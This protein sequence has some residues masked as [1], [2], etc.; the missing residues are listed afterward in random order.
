MALSTLTSFSFPQ[1]LTFP[2]PFE[3]AV[4]SDFIHQTQ[5]RVK[6]WHSPTSLSLNWTN[7]GP[8]PDKIEGI[9]KYWGNE[10]DWS[11][12]ESQ[13]N[14]NWSHYAT[15]VSTTG[16]YKAPVPL[17]FIHQRSTEA[18]AVPLLL[19][20]GW[21]STHMEWSKVI[22]PLT[23]DSSLSFHVV[24]PDLPGFG[25]SPAP[26]EPG[27]GPR[28]T[29]QVMDGLMKQ[30]GYS[31]YGIVSTDLG[32]Q[33][34]MWMTGDAQASIIGHFTDFFPV[35]STDDDLT[36]LA[37]NRTSPEET[38]Y[39][40]ALDGWFSSHSA[41]S[42][43]HGQKPL[44]LSLALTDSPVGFLG[45]VWDLI[46]A[47]SDGHEYTY[48]ELITNALMLLIPGPY[49]NIRTYLEYNKA[50]ARTFP[51]SDVPTGVSEWGSANGPFPELAH[52]PLTPRSWIERTSNVQYFVQHAYGGHFPAVSHPKEWVQ[53]V[54]N[55]FLRLP[56]SSNQQLKSRRHGPR[57]FRR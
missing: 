47:I 13:L 40:R 33:V 38:V 28:Q 1:G 32:W 25:F 35:E 23:Q 14:R 22:E 42:A 15:S 55:F 30:L 36:R 37:Q 44:A 17:H 10:Y 8:P 54:R 12:F 57:P 48:D 6:T 51:K 34:A 49:S 45:W 16:K 18:D 9:A 53:N 21:P 39:M 29:G 11:A 41:Y 4:N 5:A 50:G 26:K 31:K 20:H 27:L 24:A 7:E 3:I 19:L 52:F 56:R 2:Q 46:Y 43:I